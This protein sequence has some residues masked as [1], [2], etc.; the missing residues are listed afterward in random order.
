ML[1][2]ARKSGDAAGYANQHQATSEAKSKARAAGR[3]REEAS[4]GQ[5]MGVKEEE[6]PGNEPPAYMDAIY[7]TSYPGRPSTAESVIEAPTNGAPAATPHRRWKLSVRLNG[8]QPRPHTHETTLVDPFVDQDYRTVFEQYL[9]N[10]DR[11]P[12]SPVSLSAGSP[13]ALRPGSPDDV[14]RMERQIYGYAH[15]LLSQLRLREDLLRPKA[16][17]LQ[18]YVVEHHESDHDGA[19]A[20]G[21]HCL[22]WELLESIRLPKLPNLR[23]RVS[24]VTDFPARRT[25]RGLMSPKMQT[26]AQIQA[27]SAAMFKILLVVARD[28]SRSG[29]DRDA[30][31][32]LAQFPLMNVQKKLRSRMLLE[33]VRPGCVEDLGEHL[34]T[35][36]LQGVIFN[37]V[38][39]DLH[40]QVLPDEYG[41]PTPWLLFAKR[42][43]ATQ[44]NGYHLPQTRLARASEVANLL[45]ENQVENVVLNACLS[46]YN[47]STSLTNLSQLFLQ[48]GIQN[49]SAMWFYVHWKTVETYLETFYNQLLRKGVDFHVAAQQGR[50]AVRNI[51]TYRSGRPCK[52]DF[53]CVNYA[54]QAHRTDSMTRDP[55][56]TPSN[57]SHSSSTSN[58]SSKSFIS[59]GW[60]PSTP[61]LGDALI[62]GDEP[63][64]RMK[65]HLLE[66]EYKLTTF[67]I[68][69]ASDLHREKS[70]LSETI[71]RMVN[72]WMSTNMIDDVYYYRAKDFARSGPLA[73]GTLPSYRDKKSRGSTGG[74]LQLLFPKPVKA[75]RSTLHIIREVDDIVDPGWRADDATNAKNEERR[76]QA[77][78]GLQR[79]AR[80]LH[81]EEDS[82]CIFLGSQDAQWFR[83]FLQHL[84]GAWWL[85]MQWGLTVPSRSPIPRG[86]KGRRNDSIGSVINLDGHLG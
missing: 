61:R 85:H 47:R 54:R 79:F 55:S 7:I 10:T 80:R 16:T 56:P 53:L 51:P 63:V 41:V 20:D 12:W 14:T 8:Q 59:G 65:L 40:G 5:W 27:D 15:S 34:R 25:M 52:D 76:I 9:R 18:I 75:L 58:T 36:A 11:P 46:A 48:R 70:D 49:I 33:V 43:Y 74:Y 64:I 37:L 66:L 60:K 17:D 44:S 19:A 28:F 4:G 67:R 35:R 84:H 62:V 30:E 31:P 68:V 29:A 71:D 21:I 24:R 6:R 86:S 39:F 69:Y 77:Q 83:R 1:T 23:L 82:Y 57:K 13:V 45:V 42:T 78:E 73:A 3:R 22:A 72:M 50:E 38:H 26:L 81:T 2:R 32:D